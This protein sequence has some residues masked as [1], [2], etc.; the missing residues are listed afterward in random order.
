MRGAARTAQR[1]RSW[2]LGGRDKW[3]GVHRGDRLDGYLDSGTVSC[4]NAGRAHGAQ[5]RGVQTALGS[6][7]AAL[8]LL[9][10]AWTLAGCGDPQPDNHALVA[11]VAAGR[12]AE[13]TVQGRVVQV[14]PDEEGPEGRHERFRLQVDGWVV[15]V[16]HNLTLAPRAPVVVGA[17]VIVHGQFEPD[18]GHPVIHYTHHA[19]GAHE[20]GWIKLDGHR[21]S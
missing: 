2:N 13:V 18:P 8:G 20:G 12:P 5:N 15:E 11:A 7:A 16:D 10:L 6:R 1:G 17:T 21:Y 3:K 4:V 19:T 14:L 9:L